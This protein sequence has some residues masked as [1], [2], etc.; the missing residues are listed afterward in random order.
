MRERSASP[1]R[2]A[3][4]DSR[5]ILVTLLV[6]GWL[7][8]SGF[9]ALRALVVLGNQVATSYFGETDAM[10]RIAATAPDLVTDEMR[11]H[12]AQREQRFLL[13]RALAGPLLLVATLGIV[14]ALGLLRRRTW[15][16]P[17]L[18]TVGV[19]AIGI[20]AFHAHRTVAIAASPVAGLAESAPETRDALALL[21]AAA[22][23]NL[24]LQ[25]IPLV[26]AMSL[27]RHPVLSDY[28]GAF[29]EGRL[30]RRGR[31]V[32]FLFTGGSVL[33]VAAVVLLWKN[34]F[35]VPAPTRSAATAPRAESRETFDWGGQPMAFTPP[36]PE[37]WTRERHAEGGRKGV[38]FT[39]YA[40]PPSR[41]IV[42]EVSLDTPAAGVSGVLPRLRLT[43]ETFPSADSVL[44][45]EPVRAVVGGL[46]AFQT[47]YT[48]RERSMQHRGREFVTV[49]GGHAF[50][51]GFLGRE[52]DL[53]AFENLVASVR[54]PAAGRPDAG[55]P[56]IAEEPAREETVRGDV[57]DLQIGRHRVSVRI[58]PGWERID[59][60]Q[61]QEFRR[62][63]MRIA[64]V[65]G[66]ELPAPVRPDAFDDETVE[67]ALRLFEH[68]PRRWE[69][70]GKTLLSAGPRKALAVDT[71]DP[72]SHALHQHTI[73]LANGGR[74]LVAGTFQGTWGTTVGALDALVGSV[75]FQNEPGDPEREKPD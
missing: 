32:A 4:P 54:F 16:R 30:R 6:A 62:A 44:V 71:W 20:S 74:L 67:R 24:A 65:D 42:A 26:L 47:D 73:L 59:Y 28:L 63:E 64:L 12:L 72:L 17:L 56:V 75:R 40:V 60:G 15:S 69:I 2:L 9:G 61:R 51:L 27:L 37:A 23:I 31:Q 8:L 19:L 5:P 57:A 46:P 52:I 13:D 7:I 66:G 34:R 35:P 43:P 22:G 45:G 53:P 25:S 41:I 18:L 14:G 3:R 21:R 29:T 10:A 38:S 36:S 39:R 11:E 49:A 1:S 48:L 70:A 55:T 58:P 50:V 33:L 68:D